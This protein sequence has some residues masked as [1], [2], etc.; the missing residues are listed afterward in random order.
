MLRNKEIRYLLYLSCIVTIVSIWMGF[1]YHLYLGLFIF[2][3]HLLL[4][5]FFLYVTKYRYHRI[6]QL[7]S[8]LKET[9][10]GKDNADL[11][12]YEEGELSI[13]K[14]DIGK[15]TQ[16]LKLQSEY[17]LEDKHFLSDTLSN[18][19]HQLK[20]PLTAMMVMSDVLEDAS[21]PQEKRRDFLHQLKIQL[22]R[23][24]WLISSLLKLSK[25][26]ANT[27]I[28]HK[29]SLYLLDLLKASAEPIH[30]SMEV[31]N[32]SLEIQC[33]PTIKVE[34]DKHWTQEAILNVLKNCMEHTAEN[35]K[36]LIAC[37]DNFLHTTISISDNGTGILAEDLPYIFDRFYK[38]RNA[39]PDSVGIG[40][41]MSKTILQN[42][43]ASIHVES[44]VGKGSVFIIK[45][46]RS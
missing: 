40:L 28:F 15:L 24:E 32:Q 43:N 9:Y 7:S 31:R 38:G 36:I 27:T 44:E 10:E 12:M 17:L 34:M 25:I 30:I 33:D 1:N 2:V 4:I 37:S 5:S 20:T 46:Y 3:D 6:Q 19:S 13:L 8:Y 26:D 18:I 29:E 45:L 22:L 21:L 39:K 23:M 42:Q 16:T 41:A 35:G 11:S 14:N